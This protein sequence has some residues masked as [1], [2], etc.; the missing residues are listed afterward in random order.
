M[1]VQEYIDAVRE[2]CARHGADRVI[3]FGSRARGTNTP[4]SDFDLAVYGANG[5]YD[6]IDEIDLL[7]TLF[8]ADVVDMDACANQALIEEVRRHGLLI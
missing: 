8:S 4:N 5:I 7:P 6:I 2:I 1:K 3:L